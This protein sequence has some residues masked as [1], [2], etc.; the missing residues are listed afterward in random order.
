MNE[1]FVVCQDGYGTGVK[2]PGIVSA[3]LNYQCAHNILKSHA[4]AYRVYE[5]EFK[6]SHG[7][8]VGI[9]IDSGWYEPGTLH[10]ALF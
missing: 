3:E 7:G 8:Q 10:Y 4:R 2:A 5:T 9:T 1:A 6:E